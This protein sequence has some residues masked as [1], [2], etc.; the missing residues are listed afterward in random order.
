MGT[1]NYNK[2]VKIDFPKSM[3]I[4]SPELDALKESTKTI[5]KILSQH[6]QEIAKG[7]QSLT[8]LPDLFTQ[9]KEL[10]ANQFN[11]L[12]I[13]S[14]ETNI[15]NRQ[16]NVKVL[17]K[18]IAFVKE[19]VAKKERQLEKT[20]DQ[21]IE[22]FAN[23]S[24]EMTKEH[25]LFLQKL[26]SHAYEI[27][28]QIYPRQIQERF[29]YDTQPNI[30]YLVNHTTESGYVRSKCITDSFIDARKKVEYFLEERKILNDN[31]A[32]YGINTNLVDGYYSLPVWFA[33]IINNETEEKEIKLIFPWTNND[34]N[35][36]TI[37]VLEQMADETLGALT[38]Y[39]GN[40]DEVFEKELQSWLK[41][42]KIPKE[43][44]I[45]FNEDCEKIIFEEEK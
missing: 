7:I 19:H 22:R 34:I 36:E 9:L 8:K 35:P 12:F 17:G 26:D 38:D 24:K 31:L 6:L 20:N 18:K 29:S 5:V 3:K 40:N 39:S 42:N 32:E 16:A 21:I 25:E 4:Q 11:N 28:D 23:I 15:M 30:D 45:R 13:A 14:V 2:P 1:N 10:V 37:P 27:V 43:E 33:E 44:L 41:A